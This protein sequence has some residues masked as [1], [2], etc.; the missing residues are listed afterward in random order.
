[1]ILGQEPLGFRRTG[2][3]PV[4]SLLMSAFSLPDAPPQLTRQLHCIWN[5]P[6]PLLRVYGFGDMLEPRYIYGAGNLDQ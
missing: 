2:F 1:M 6:L 4:L 3:S 5:A